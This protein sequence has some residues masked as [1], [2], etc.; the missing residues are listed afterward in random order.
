[1][2]PGDRN[3]S[4]GGWQ[5]EKR[6]S[7]I[8][9]SFYLPNLTEKTANKSSVGIVLRRLQRG[10]I[11]VWLGESERNP[12]TITGRDYGRRIGSQTRIYFLGVD[13]SSGIR[14][15][16]QIKTDSGKAGGFKVMVSGIVLGPAGMKD[17]KQYKP[18]DTIR[19]VWSLEDYKKLLIDHTTEKAN[20]NKTDKHDD[21][22]SKEV[23]LSPSPTG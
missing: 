14:H 13:I 5:S 21:P 12:V 8:E 15:T 22:C 3:D 19:K 11:K 17:I 16:L 20:K 4:F 6:G 18:S 2:H 1:M 9:L 10:S 7:I 23:S